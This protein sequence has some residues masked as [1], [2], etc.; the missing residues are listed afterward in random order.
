MHFICIYHKTHTYILCYVVQ[1]GILHSKMPYDM[2]I[3]RTIYVYHLCC[4]SVY[5]VRCT[6]Y[7]CTSYIVYRKLI[8]TIVYS[9]HVYYTSY[10]MCLHCTMYNIHYIWGSNRALY[11]R[12]IWEYIY[13]SAYKGCFDIYIQWTLYI[14]QWTLYTI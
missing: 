10:T 3:H 5:I 9:P 11:I 13:S 4:M 12:Y 2:V 1:H 7:H 14:I 8:Y 6:P